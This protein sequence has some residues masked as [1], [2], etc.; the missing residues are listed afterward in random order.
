LRTETTASN[1]FAGINAEAFSPAETMSI[2][3]QEYQAMRPKTNRASMWRG[4]K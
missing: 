1:N 2:S 3:L 4:K